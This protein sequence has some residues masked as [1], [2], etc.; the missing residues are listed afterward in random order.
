MS[1][2]RN[3]ITRIPLKETDAAARRAIENHVRLLRAAYPDARILET[4]VTLVVR[5]SYLPPSASMTP[6]THPDGD[7]TR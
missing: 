4:N 1:V 2:R 6:T 3:H 7:R 5:S